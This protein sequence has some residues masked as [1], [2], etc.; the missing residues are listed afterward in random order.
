MIGPPR[1]LVAILFAALSAGCMKPEYEN[2]IGK[3][4]RHVFGDGRFQI[5]KF[6]NDLALYDHLLNRGVGSSI[7]EW[8]ATGQ[9][10]YVRCKDG[11]CASANY[12]DG[13]VT[14][15]ASIAD[16]PESEREFFDGS[17]VLRACP[18]SWRL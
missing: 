5:C 7:L 10:V 4:T 16:V 17:P 13:T 11:T 2:S 9:T 15:Y 6:A 3:D 1:F 14:N 8:S 12:V 18:K